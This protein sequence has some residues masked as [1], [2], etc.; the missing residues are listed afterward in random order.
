MV[1]YLAA[2]T[3]KDSTFKGGGK[4]V[5]AEDAVKLVET[6]EVVGKLPTAMEGLTPEL[7]GLRKANAL[8]NQGLISKDEIDEYATTLAAAKRKEVDEKE[9]EA[10]DRKSV[11]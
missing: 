11:V 5:N 8:F 1:Q 9:R 7:D 4:K 6:V 2:T 10:T 3:S